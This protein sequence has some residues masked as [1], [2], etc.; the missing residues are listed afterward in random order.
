L[1]RMK[2]ILSRK[3]GLDIL[4]RFDRSKVLVIGDIMVDHFIWGS[5]SR[6]SPEAP[7][8]VVEVAK[9]SLLFGGSGNVLNNIIALGGSP[10]LAG[11]IGKDEMGDWLCRNLKD[12]DVDT[13]GLIVEKGRPTT[14]KTR[15][16]AHHQ[17]M[18]RFD[19][20]SKRKIDGTSLQKMLNHIE[21]LKN[22]VRA[23]IISDY[24]KGVVSETLLN[25]I[26]KINFGHSAAICVDPK[27]NDFSLYR[28]VDVITPNH[29][30]AAHA[31]GL[32]RINGSEAPSAARISR[33]AID[34]LKRLD[35]KA[36]LITRG[37]EGMS[38]FERDGNVIH[39]PAVAKEVFD[40]TGAGDTVIGV[41]A[42]SLAAGASFK[43]AAVLANHAAGIVV[44]KIGTATVSRDELQRVL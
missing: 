3:R 30:E 18:V 38:L 8:P 14:I 4:K 24:N 17:Q 25:G 9:E 28:G 39:I 32:E 7:V 41:F 43:E 26:R 21:N 16:V 37:E 12:I 15:I 13:R 23:I 31:L 29:H 20:E 35:I 1:E 6:V 34:C 19:R 33:E 44:G 11:I 2:K 22:E 40:V 42:L 36:L 10:S 5:V 27:Q